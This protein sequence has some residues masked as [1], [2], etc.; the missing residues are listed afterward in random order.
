MI[1]MASKLAERKEREAKTFAHGRAQGGG[2]RV[3]L[4]EF[5]SFVG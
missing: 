1:L 3:G 2:E 5:K 4:D